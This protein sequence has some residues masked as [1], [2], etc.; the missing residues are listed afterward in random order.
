[1]NK[2]QIPQNIQDFISAHHVLSLSTVHKGA[3]SSCS[4]FYVFIEAQKCFVFASQDKSEHIQNILQNNNVSACIHD[5]VREVIRIKGLQVKAK[6]KRAS[7]EYEKVYFES[8]PEA[9]DFEK[10]I[11]VLDIVELKYTD[12]KVLGLGEKEKWEV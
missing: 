8:Y 6:A 11:W 3:V 10:G 1:M 7:K 9:K 12:N 5:E 4:V 2:A